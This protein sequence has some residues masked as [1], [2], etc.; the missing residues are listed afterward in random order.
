MPAQCHEQC[1]LDERVV[2][3]VDDAGTDAGAGS[4]R[5]AE[6]DVADLRD[7][8]IGE[9]ALQ[10]VLENRDQRARQHRGD[11]QPHEDIADVHVIERELY[12]EHGK[13]Q[14]QQDV[15]THLGGRGGEEDARP[16]RVRRYRHSAAR[17]AAG[18]APA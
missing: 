2:E 14:P 9:H 5:D 8:G 7:A 4:Q 6:H 3:Q 10:V 17:C 13:E 18:T 15:H 1:A 16:P 11:R 12:P